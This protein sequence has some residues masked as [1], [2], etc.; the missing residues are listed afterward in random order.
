MPH[1]IMQCLQKIPRFIA[2]IKLVLGQGAALQPVNEVFIRAYA[3]VSE[4]LEGYE[5]VQSEFSVSWLWHDIDT[6]ARDISDFGAR[7]V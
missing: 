2:V 1:C 3:R 5:S 7:D 6:V 4:A